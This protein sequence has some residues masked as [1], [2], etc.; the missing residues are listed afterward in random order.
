MQIISANA[1]ARIIDRHIDDI[2]KT[3]EPVKLFLRN[4]PHRRRFEEALTMQLQTADARK[5]IKQ[6]PEHIDQTIRDIVK[7][8]SGKMIEFHE[9][10]LLSQNELRRQLDEK[11]QIEIA[12]D[13]VRDITPNIDED[14]FSVRET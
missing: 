3:N 8:W 5:M 9:A 10:S 14:D 4:H 11:R 6:G 2:F 12:E 7:F 1:A 13:I